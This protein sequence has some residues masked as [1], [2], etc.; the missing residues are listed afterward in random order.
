MEQSNFR[1]IQAIH[2]HW[3]GFLRLSNSDHSVVHEGPDDKGTYEISGQ[4]LT[5]RWEKYSP[6]V[7]VELSGI[8]VAEPLLQ[9]LPRAEHMFA[10]T[11]GSKPVLATRA[12]V[13]LPDSAYQVDLRLRTSDIPTFEQ[14]FIRR[15]YE[16]PDLPPFANSIVD[17]GANIGLATVFFGLKYP[18]AHILSVEPEDSNF[19]A[20]LS[21]T[22]ALGDRVQKRRAAVWKTNGFINLHT[23]SETGVSLDAWGVQVSDRADQSNKTTKCYELGTLLDEAGFNTVDILKVDIEGAELEVFSHCADEWLSRVGLII[24]ETHDRFRPG[25]DWAVRNAIDAMFDELPASGE[26]LLFRRKLP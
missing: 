23:E 5:V 3:T 19:A 6:D 2:R 16:S 25:S 14:V 21:N 20:L 11:V 1:R 7:F 9:E 13:A 18:T 26:N 4:K 24:I 8:Y 17:L 10:I 15:E 22:E 12:S